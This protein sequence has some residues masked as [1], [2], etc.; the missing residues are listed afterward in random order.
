MPS[1]IPESWSRITAWFSSNAPAVIADLNPPAS[2]EDLARIETTL[3]VTLPD[4]FKALYRIHD[5]QRQD[6]FGVFFGLF[7]LSLTRLQQRWDTWRELLEADPDLAAGQDVPRSSTPVGTIKLRYISTGWIPFSE[8]GL[9]AHLGLDFDP[10]V[11]GS[12]GQIINF[13]RYDQKKVVIAQDFSSFLEWVATDLERGKARMYEAEGLKL[14][15]HDDLKDGNLED[16][17]IKLFG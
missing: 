12:V 3:G 16:G 10:D 13:G 14:F 8:N 7:F 6:A 17:L 15:G 4:D 2:D 11:N 5:G 9:S 1:T